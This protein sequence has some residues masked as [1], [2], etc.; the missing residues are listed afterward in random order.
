[1]SENGNQEQIYPNNHT[2]T[3]QKGKHQYPRLEFPIKESYIKT[4][5]SYIKD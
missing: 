4:S 2:A 3:R 1:M 5:S